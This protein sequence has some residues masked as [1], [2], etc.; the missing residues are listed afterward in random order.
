MDMRNL[1]QEVIL[2]HNKKP[3]NFGPL[4]Q[5][6]RTA[7]GYNPLCG[8][9]YEVHLVVE[10]DIVQEIKFEGHGCAI[11]K[12]A[13]SMMTARVKGKPVADAEVL[14]RQFRQMMADE[15]DEE[16]ET[17]LGHLKVFKGVS[18]LPN[19]IKCAVLPW[20]TLNAA[21]KGEEIASTEGESDEWAEDQVE[22]D[23]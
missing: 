10:D 9:D 15:A 4:E 3:R 1:Y 5:A 11:S 21:L 17:A 20:H 12:A 7:H 18:Q 23:Q 22:P 8:D 14:V 16:S 6:N 13:A 19:R 2:D